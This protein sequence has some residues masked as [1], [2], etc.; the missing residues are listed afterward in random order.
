MHEFSHRRYLTVKSS[1]KFCDGRVKTSN[2][3]PLTLYFVLQGLLS[4]EEPEWP[5]EPEVGAGDVSSTT[6]PTDGVLVIWH[7]PLGFWSYIS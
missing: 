5:E 1:W 2:I 3:L 6:S 7:V 4:P